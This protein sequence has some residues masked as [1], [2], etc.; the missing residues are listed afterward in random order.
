VTIQTNSISIASCLIQNFCESLRIMDLDVNAIFPS[1]FK[2]LE[3]L[4]LQKSTFGDL[5][6]QSVSMSS[7]VCNNIQALLL[8]AED[9]RQIGEM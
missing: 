4:L 3:S 2:T 5:K 7:E 8:H 9:C 6:L 1:E